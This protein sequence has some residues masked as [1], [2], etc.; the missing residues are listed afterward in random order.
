M[1]PGAVR[2]LLV[3]DSASDALLLQESLGETR[4]GEFEFTHVET[5]A[6]AARRLREKVFEVL[7]LDLS[8]PDITGRET[9]LRA[10]AEAPHLPIV[11]LTGEAN[12]ALGLDA[13]RHGVQD[14]LIK[15]QAYGMQTARAIRYALERKQVEDALERTQAA[16][17]ESERQLRESNQ[18]LE[19][20]VAERTASLAETISDLEDFSHSITHDLRAPLRAIR[21][22]AQI[23]GEECLTCGRTQAQEHIQ[24]IT[25]AAARMDKL[26]LDV[27][28]YSRLA[29]S[30]LRLAPVD[31]HELLRGIVES[32][33]AF[34]PTEVDI[35]ID[36]PLPRVLG[37]EAALTQCFSNLLGNAIKFV[38]PGTRPHI[39]IWAEW[40]GN[41]K[42]EIR[43]PKEGR[44]PKS[45]ARAE[46]L[47][48]GGAPL[49]PTDYRSSATQH[50][51]R[52]TPQASTFDSLT[53]QPST[54]NHLVRLWFEDNGVGIP[55]EAQDRIF[56]MFQRLDKSYD[57]TGVGLTVVRKAVEKMGG[58]VGLESEPG[59]G[60]RFWV[61]LRAADQPEAPGRAG[62]PA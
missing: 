29:R 56:K 41:P 2:V 33:P 1:K 14:Y 24:R 18:E 11:V 31:V 20:R 10:R 36:S 16:L 55:K 28:Q 21:S 45:E 50:A 60:S 47:A 26:I 54:L 57:G 30:E 62:G 48:A 4:P 22:F 37:N 39:L 12:E 5:W 23:L 17:R 43:G 52:N 27:L 34:Q 44:D 61:E 35:Q 42:P 53:P 59:K 25:S 13:V 38:P 19:F 6:E 8:L 32:Y 51:T 7:L 15:G 46:P 58:R 3:E 9:F 49:P 40:L